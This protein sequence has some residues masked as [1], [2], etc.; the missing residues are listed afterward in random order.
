MIVVVAGD[1][2]RWP[3]QQGQDPDD[4]LAEHGWVGTP[5]RAVLGEADEVELH[6]DATP[7]AGPAAPVVVTDALPGARAHQRLGAYAI[8]VDE[9][10][11]LMAQLSEQVG[12]AAGLW[13]FPGGGV[14]PGEEPIRGVVREVHEEAGQ[15]VIVD[16]LV[17]V[18]SMHWIDEDA[19]VG[20]REDFHAVRLIYRAHCPRPT[21]A[22]V[23]EIDGSTG[24]AAWVPIE[25]VADLPLVRMVGEAWPFVPG[26]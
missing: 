1:V 23:V 15:H 16:D 4:V 12:R 8:V 18:Q 3:L 5:V 25:D 19:A 13:G 22:H 17:Q 2:G 20:E 7:L 9:D 26:T 14:D 11:L 24:D 10:R 21:A 6:Y